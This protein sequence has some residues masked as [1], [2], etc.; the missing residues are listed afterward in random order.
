MPPTSLIQPFA[1]SIRLRMIWL[2]RYPAW[3]VDRPSMFDPRYA[4]MFCATCGVTPAARLLATNAA[5][6]YALSAPTVLYQPPL[7]SSLPR[8]P[9]SRKYDSLPLKR[10]FAA[11][12]DG[13]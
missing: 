8:F 10:R 11:E 2:T 7:N 9:G 4:L 1:S 3:R 6:S 13:G 5:V 12:E